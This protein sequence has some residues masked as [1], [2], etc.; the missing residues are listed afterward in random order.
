MK[1]ILL[2]LFALS[3]VAPA[4]QAQDSGSGLGVEITGGTNHSR[5][6]EDIDGAD[7]LLCWF[8]GADI[9]FYQSG[10]L[11]FSSGMHYRGSGSEYKSNEDFGEGGSYSF[12]TREGLN[13][14]YIP[15]EVRYEFGAGKIKPFVRG[16]GAFGFLL[17]A[18]SKTKTSFNGQ[19]NEAETDIKDQKKSTNLALSL[20]GG[21]SFPLGK[22]RGIASVRYLI[23]LTNVV[24]DDRAPSAK[25]RDLSYS[26]GIG[27]PIL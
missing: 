24:K 23:G 6:S 2:M 16:G 12:E 5:F 1:K 18:K 22:Y 10:P 25:T 8:F 3:F 9:I 15:A 20:G 21:I 17:S 14:L 27:I 26:V 7:C 11:Q 4:L 19:E 13:Y